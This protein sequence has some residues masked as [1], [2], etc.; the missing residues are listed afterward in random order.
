MSAKREGKDEA[1]LGELDSSPPKGFASFR[2]LVAD[3]LESRWTAALT[4]VRALAHPEGFT[5][6]DYRKL[7]RVDRDEAY[8]EIRSLVQTGV[9]RE[10]EAPGRGAV[11]R[12]APD[13]HEARAFLEGRILSLREHSHRQARLRNADYRVRFGLTRHAARR[14]LRRLVEQG[15]LRLEGERRGGHYLPGA[16]LGAAGK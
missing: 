14:E 5:N 11:Y 7:N 8:R 1:P 15:V 9:L 16:V 2:S 13:L 4:R 3:E 12:V 6:E 10:A